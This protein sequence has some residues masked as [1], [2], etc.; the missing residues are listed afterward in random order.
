MGG[1]IFSEEG[2][3]LGGGPNFPGP[4]SIKGREGGEFSPFSLKGLIGGQSPETAKKRGVL[5]TP[6]RGGGERPTFFAGRTGGEK[7]GGPKIPTNPPK[8]IGGSPSKKILSKKNLP[9][10]NPPRGGGVLPAKNIPL[11]W[12]LSYKKGRGGS[13]L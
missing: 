11:L 5:N 4:P 6:Q 1:K 2:P 13:L 12:G 10:K 9:P 7:R 8:N 3:V